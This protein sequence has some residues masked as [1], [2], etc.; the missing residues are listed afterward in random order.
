MAK[1]KILVAF[2]AA[3]ILLGFTESKSQYIEDALR[4]TNSNGIITPRAAG[5]NVAF[6]GISD[7]FAGIMYNPA[8]LVLIPKD[9]FSL[10]F[11]FLRNSSQS[12]FHSQLT[13][14]KS[15]SEFLS[16]VGFVTPVKF[17]KTPGALAIGYFNESNYSNSVD[18]TAF[19]PR[20]SFIQSETNFGPGDPQSNYA[21]QL[22][23]ADTV[24]NGGNYSFVTPYKDSLTQKAFVKETGGMHDVAASLAFDANENISLGF[25]VMG[26]FG[27][28][29][30]TRDFTESDD[31]GKYAGTN[32]EG[33]VFKSVTGS[34]NL[35]AKISGI[36]GSIG[37][38]AR[39]EDILRFGATIKF[40]TWYQVDETF[41]YKYSAQ[42]VT[43][44]DPVLPLDGTG[45]NSYN[46]STP[47]TYAAGVSAHTAGLTFAAG[48]EYKD[49]TQMEFSDAVSEVASLNSDIVRE[50]VGQT[51]WG[52]GAEYE[53]PIFP[54][55]V[56]AG[57]QKTTSPYQQDIPNASKS[58]FSIGGGVFIG[59]NVRI[60][61][62]FRYSDYSELR[63]LYA[64]DAS[65]S[66]YARYVL[67]RSPLQIAFG[68]TYRY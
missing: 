56:R 34:E 58:V 66:D 51:T 48:V 7:D 33:Y 46:L 29:G 17:D 18:Y 38:M 6:Y 37:I 1:S 44:P 26:K 47:F 4:Y 62:V 3:G 9:E 42:Y 10:G 64:S 45:K 57:F 60:D 31:M 35:D 15:N 67:N 11:G 8:G 36:T 5:L 19:N 43:Q 53:L 16:N 59:K 39:L 50:L 49:V 55:V 20:S 21:Y 54:G 30:Y 61:G 65:L 41:S 22:F 40:P 23:L 68:L 2:M 24:G 12:D 32:I 13:D 25:T 27:S 28:Y 14:F 63:Q 52:F